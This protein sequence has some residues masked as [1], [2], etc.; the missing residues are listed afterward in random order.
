MVWEVWNGAR[1]QPAPKLRCLAGEEGEAA[2]QE[3][4]AAQ[5]DKEPDADEDSEDDDDNWPG[6]FIVLAILNVLAILFSLSRLASCLFRI[7]RHTDTCAWTRRRRGGQTRA[8]VP[9]FDVD[10]VSGFDVE[11]GSTTS[12]SSG[13]AQIL[14]PNISMAAATA[15]VST[16]RA[17]LSDE[18]CVVNAKL[19][20]DGSTALHHGAKEGHANIVREL[21]DHSADCLVVDAALKTPLHYVAAHGHGL[22]VKALLDAG[23]DPESK[24]ASGQ[25]SLA[26]ADANG[27]VGTARVMRQHIESRAAEGRAS[28]RRMR[29]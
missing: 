29:V 7:C 21:L 24:D 20:L 28:L 13:N 1:W 19:A 12:T 2:L 10:G 15:D 18:Q 17:W 6:W 23:A 16:L 27:H 8:T 14:H 5:Q 25:T 3:M 22:C 9:G 11:G 26:L 4:I